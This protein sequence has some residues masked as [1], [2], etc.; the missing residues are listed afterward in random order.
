MMIASMIR[1]AVAAAVT[2]TARSVAV[3]SGHQG[4]DPLSRG[5]ST[6]ARAK[7]LRERPLGPEPGER[8]RLSRSV[9][10]VS[11]HAA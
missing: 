4:I 7:R 2:A 9:Y 11:P 3:E 10:R 8:A 6:S 5:I 1:P